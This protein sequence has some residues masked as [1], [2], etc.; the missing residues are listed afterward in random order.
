MKA[1]ETVGLTNSV[2]RTLY[3]HTGANQFY[4]EYYIRPDAQ[5]LINSVCENTPNIETAK[6]IDAGC[7]NGLHLRF[8]QRV[9]KGALY[10]IDVSEE[11]LIKAENE[12][13]DYKGENKIIYKQ[14]DL[15]NEQICPRLG[16][17]D[18]YFDVLISSWMLSHSQTV[19]E[20]RQTVKNL[21]NALRNGGKVY[22]LTINPEL[23]PK[24]FPKFLKYG[25]THVPA[26]QTKEVLDDEDK[27]MFTLY[28]LESKKKIFEVPDYYY[29][30]E[31]MEKAFKDA[32]FKILEMEELSRVGKNK[33]LLG[34]D[35]N[36]AV[37]F[38]LQKQ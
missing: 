19:A 34:D 18:G 9:T 21:A 5:C 4:K 2:K 16:L 8:L 30:K 23:T 38:E 20:L 32:G 6:V 12:V 29:S 22:G 7:G 3:S 13:T 35:L 14:V 26:N 10:G 17:P 15:A 25:F 28:D 33:E 31:T 1:A 27:L 37:Y 11:M 24:D 36:N